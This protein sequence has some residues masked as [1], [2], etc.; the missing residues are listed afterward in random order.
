MDVADKWWFD[1]REELVILAGEKSPVRIYIDEILN[2]VLFDFLCIDTVERVF[3]AVSY[4]HL[5]AHET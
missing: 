5:R 2:E 4:T 1:R 3:Y